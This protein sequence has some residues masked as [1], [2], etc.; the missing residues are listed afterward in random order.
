MGHSHP[1]HNDTVQ[2]QVGHLGQAEA[3]ARKEHKRLHSCDALAPQIVTKLT[4]WQK[5][6]ALKSIMTVKEKRDELLE[7]RFVADRRKQ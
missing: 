2:L 6:M 5:K 4:P 1:L 7:G 3:V